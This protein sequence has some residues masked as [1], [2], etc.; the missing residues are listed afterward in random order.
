M[1]MAGCGITVVCINVLQQIL[2]GLLTVTGLLQ[3]SSLSL[4]RLVTTMTSSQGITAGIPHH[5]LGPCTA[6]SARMHFQ[7]Q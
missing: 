6:T 2:T 5:M 3:Y 7:V 1:S 4:F